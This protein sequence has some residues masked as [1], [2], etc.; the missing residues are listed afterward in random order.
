MKLLKTIFLTLIITLFFGMAGNCQMFSFEQSSYQKKA[1]FSAGTF[2]KGFLQNQLS[3]S[4]NKVG[5]SVYVI[6][7]YG[8]KIGKIT[9]IPKNTLITGHI[10]QV[11]KPVTGYNGYIQVKFDYIT[12][13]DG[14]GT[15]FS[16]HVW[17]LG[18]KGI[19][20]GEATNKTLYRKIPHYMENVGTVVQLVAVGQGAMGK[21]TTV[22]K[23]TEFIIVLDSDLNVTVNLNQ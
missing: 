5:D 4:E 11:G 19:L 8:V 6:I 23:N 10:T 20:G 17:N 9:C 15:T 22:E 16:G 13:P 3:S 18:G 2:L 7:P 1:T 14:W 21:E 12:F